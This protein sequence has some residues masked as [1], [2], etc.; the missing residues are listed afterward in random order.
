M[1]GTV[2]ETNQIKNFHLSNGKNS[3]HLD[4]VNQNNARI[5]CNIPHSIAKRLLKQLTDLLREGGASS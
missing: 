3:L 5:P 4:L 2:F 1:S